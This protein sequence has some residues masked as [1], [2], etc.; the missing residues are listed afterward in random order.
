MRKT[1][2]FARDSNTDFPP[3]GH[4]ADMNA[5]QLILLSPYQYPAQHALTLAEDEMAAWMNGWSAL[6]HPA[7]LWGA[8][9]PPRVDVPYDHENPQADFV[10]VL[11]ETPP[12]V[13]PEDWEQRIGTAGAMLVKSSADRDAT[14]KMA[15]EQYGRLPA[16]PVEQVLGQPEHSAAEQPDSPGQASEVA[17]TTPANDTAPSPQEIQPK[18]LALDAAQVKPF[19]ALGL[20]YL[21]QSALSQGMEHENLLETDAFWQDIQKA[22][23]ELAGIATEAPHLPPVGDTTQAGYYP[24]YGNGTSA[25][26]D[27]P[28]YEGPAQADGTTGMTG[29]QGENPGATEGGQEHNAGPEDPYSGYGGASNSSTETVSETARLEPWLAHL[30]AAARRLQSAREVL[31][32]VTLYLLEIFL[33]DDMRLD[34][35]WPA[36]FASDRPL[37]VIAPSALLE[38]LRRE[39]PERFTALRDAVQKDQV[40]VCGGCY[41]EREDALL[42]VESQLWNLVKGQA[43]ARELLG[44]PL[45]VFARRRFGAHPQLPMLLLNTGLHRGLFLAL[46]DSALPQYSTPVVTWT[47]TDGKQVEAFVRAP[48]PGDNVETAFNLGHYLFKTIREDHSATVAF[49]HRG[50]TPAP[51]IEDFQELARFGPLFGQWVTF[52][53]YFNE[54]M[55]GE[56]VEARSA[57]DFHFDY[58]SE[59]TGDGEQRP[60]TTQFPVS[61]LARHARLRR[62]LDSCWTLAAMQRGLAGRADPLRLEP[63]LVR[64]EDVLETAGPSFPDGHE[65]IREELLQVERQILGVLADRLLSRATETAPGYLV[66][67]PCGYTRRVALE[68]DRPA[69]P[70]PIQD[71]VKA[72]QLDSDKL[73]LVV[74]VPALGFA[75]LPLSGPPGTPAPPL[76]LRLADDRHVRNEF[77]E[78]EIDPRTGGL[79]RIADR[80]SPIS[81]LAQRLVFNPGSGMQVDSIKATSVGP[82]LGEVVT[83]GRIVGEQQQ[84]LAHFRQRFRAWLGRPVLEIRIEIH[85]EQPAAGYPWH[86]YFGCRF[87]WGDERSLVLRGVNGTGY[88]TTHT[89]PQTPDFLELR[90]HRLNTVIF[91]CGLP[92]LQ[93]QETRMVDVILLP[94][95]ETART[96]DLAIG[97]DREYPMLTAQGL[98]TPVSMVAT[99]KGPPHIG[100][101]GWLYHLDRPNLLLTGMRPGG[102]ENT[103]AAM[104]GTGSQHGDEHFDA[105]TA[106]LLEIGSQSTQAQF[107][108]V[109]NP[110]RAALLN[111]AGQRQLDAFVTEDAVNLDVSSGDFTQLQVE[112][113]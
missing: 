9:G 36:S 55:A 68:L 59:R 47:S 78:A 14:L 103:A 45:E 69:Y 3:D 27:A 4:S 25:S 31:Y 105:L 101:K 15:L 35:P 71:P 91:P 19:L 38:N 65:K 98:A 107:R 17:A 30:H 72:C 10:Y 84:E 111:A 42:P 95:G 62:R 99:P 97:L 56:Y 83:E 96:F 113:S 34:G 5:R 6:W 80:R 43:V 22:L 112:F 67:N 82:A 79:S 39:Q 21:L 41:V 75:W 18:L 50:K 94:P 90:G 33:P 102:Q 23:A 66:M 40:Q 63:K 106:R 48:H 16:I 37:N 86:A 58:L 28:G 74:E 64:L 54:V 32:P 88:I 76:R 57:D 93:R 51:W 110:R 13:L 104:D 60:A 7:V 108:C 29:Y 77:F 70:L 1:A 46:D 11:P 52:A 85:P 92:F 61:G 24:A 89:R 2:S 87:A 12:S 44:K 109:R 81:R 26:Y 100:A 49:L 53:R 73:R 8:Q 20:G